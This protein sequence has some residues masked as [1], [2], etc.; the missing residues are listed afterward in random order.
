MRS[1]RLGMCHHTAKSAESAI[2]ADRCLRHSRSATTTARPND[3]SRPRAAVHGRT[4]G[5]GVLREIDSHVPVVK[6][7]PR[8]R[9]GCGPGAAV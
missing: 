9:T 3:P 7:G 2:T 1:Y 4:R 8:S 5:P 6:P